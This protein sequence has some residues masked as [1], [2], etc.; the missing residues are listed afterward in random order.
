MLIARYRKQPIEK[1]R[2]AV[3]YKH[4]LAEDEVLISVTEVLERT[5]AVEAS[6]DPGDF[7]VSG[8]TINPL[9]NRALLFF[10][11]GGINGEVWKVTLRVTTSDLQLREDEIEFMIDEV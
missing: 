4:W 11:E 7:A 9:D 8:L 10:A 6:G 1:L 3:S 5:L 2:R